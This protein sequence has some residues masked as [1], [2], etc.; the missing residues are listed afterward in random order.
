MM[1]L[2][3]ELKKCGEK[4][5]VRGTRTYCRPAA[6][7]DVSAKIIMIKTAVVR[8]QDSAYLCFN[9]HSVQ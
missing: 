1:M 9:M 5:I 6:M 3:N 4:M 7:R 2:N 8:T